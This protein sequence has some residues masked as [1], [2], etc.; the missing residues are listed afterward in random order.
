MFV[1]QI[2]LVLI[3]VLKPNKNDKSKLQSLHNKYCGDASKWG[4]GKECA[5]NWHKVSKGLII[6]WSYWFSSRYSCDVR[7]VG[8]DFTLSHLLAPIWNHK[9]CMCS[10]FTKSCYAVANTYKSWA[11]TLQKIVT[12]NETIANQEA[13][14]LKGE[15]QRTWDT[16]MVKH[17]RQDR[18]QNN[19][20][21]RSYKVSVNGIDI[22]FLKIDFYQYLF[23]KFS[24]KG[25]QKPRASL[26]SACRSPDLLTLKS[27]LTSQ[28]FSFWESRLRLLPNGIR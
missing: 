28:E 26:H 14:W 27:C 25:A 18:P 22:V 24:V 13:S 21:I 4:V 11:C 17:S 1:F 7:C 9:Y 5:T 2:C 23:N 19:L 20:L 3:G 10:V 16:A 6:C 12:W 15:A 8:R